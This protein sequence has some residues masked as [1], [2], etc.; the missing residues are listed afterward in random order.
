MSEHSQEEIEDRLWREIDKGRFGM[1]G[2][3]GEQTQHFQPM[4]AFVER[5]DGQIWFFTYRDTELARGVGS[6]RHEGAEAMFV[7]QSKDQDVQ[8]C[9][10]GRLVEDHDQDRI[11]ILRPLRVDPKDARRRRQSHRGRVRRTS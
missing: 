4:T 1:L 9:I 3:V 10:G 2:L 6:H 5:D 7:I 11:E 8:A